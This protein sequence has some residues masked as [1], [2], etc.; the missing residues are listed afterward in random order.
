VPVKLVIYD[1]LGRE[2]TTLVNEKLNHGT[3]VADWD[4]TN[5]SSGVY[6]YKLI[7]GEFIETK[8]MVLIK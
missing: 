3:Y 1:V 6:F 5:Y 7:T 8:K 4:G 2:V